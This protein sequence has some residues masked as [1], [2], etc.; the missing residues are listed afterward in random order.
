MFDLL[1]HRYDWYQTERYVVITIL[2]KNLKKEDV[3]TNIQEK[4]VREVK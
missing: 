4:E 2:I 1:T 3:T